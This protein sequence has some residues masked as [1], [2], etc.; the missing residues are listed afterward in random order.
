M[1]LSQIIAIL[2]FAA[3]VLTFGATYLGTIDPHYSVYAL[4][5]SA[6]ISAFTSKIQATA[7]VKPEVKA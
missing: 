3:T 1:K 4:A 5:I 7:S 6:A 2:S